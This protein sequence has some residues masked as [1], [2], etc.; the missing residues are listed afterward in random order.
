M[1][2]SQKACVG[3]HV[4]QQVPL[5]SASDLPARTCTA[6]QPDGAR[7]TPRP[8]GTI[9]AGDHAVSPGRGRP[10]GAHRGGAPAPPHGLAG[11]R[12]CARR[13]S[14]ASCARAGFGGRCC[15]QLGGACTRGGGSGHG[16]RASGGGGGGTPRA[17]RRRG[18][19]GTLGGPAAAAALAVA[20]AA[21]RAAAVTGGPSGGGGRWGTPVTV[22]SLSLNRS[23]RQTEARWAFC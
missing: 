17:R 20:V 7:A 16:A 8:R 4:K 1:T 6:R 18:R 5:P 13:R 15:R 9:A 23:H 21:G 12:R 19:G 11:P 2:S 14:R 10:P 3:C 22:C